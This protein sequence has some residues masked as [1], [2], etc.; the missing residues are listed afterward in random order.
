MSDRRWLTGEPV[1]NLAT[2]FQQAHGRPR[3]DDGRG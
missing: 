2:F 1:A 3:V